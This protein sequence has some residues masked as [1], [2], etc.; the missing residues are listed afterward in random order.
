MKRFTALLAAVALAALVS[1]AGAKGL[2]HAAE[3]SGASGDRWYHAAL[4]HGE[5]QG[6]RWGVGAKLPKHEP[7]DEICL[8]AVYL[9][10]P[11]PDVPYVEESD[12]TVCGNLKRP[13]ESVSLGIMLGASGA[14]F[15]A[16]LYSPIVRKV[17][18]LLSTGERRVFRPQA[19]RIPNRKAMGIPSFGYVI[20]PIDRGACVRA[21]TTFDRKGDRV[22]QVGESCSGRA[23]A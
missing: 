8:L 13:T 17:V 12:L 3:A 5:T 4:E 14:Q 15:Q 22:S 18:F 6:F 16:A 20:A 2:S 19:P 23:P 10:P 1:H 11:E 21:V 7:L 9:V